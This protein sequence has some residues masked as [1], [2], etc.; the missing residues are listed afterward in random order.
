[1]L[2]N[3]KWYPIPFGVGGRSFPKLAVGSLKSL[4]NENCPAFLS[5][6]APALGRPLIVVRNIY[7]RVDARRSITIHARARIVSR[8]F[9]KKKESFGSIIIY[10]IVFKF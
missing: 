7:V 8:E 3:L 10:F 6:R 1:M 4:S 2:S 5:S 9:M